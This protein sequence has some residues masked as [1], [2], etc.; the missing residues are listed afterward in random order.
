[1]S[2]DGARERVLVAGYVPWALVDDR[3]LVIWFGSADHG[4]ILAIDLAAPPAPEVTVETIATGLPTETEAGPLVGT[5]RYG[6]EELTAGNPI[7]PHVVLDLSDAPTL[8]LDA[9]IL[10]LWEQADEVEQALARAALPGRDRAAAFAARS[11]GRRT[12][13]E[14]PPGEASRVEVPVDP[15]EDEDLC[16]TAESVPGTGLWRVLVGHS[17]GDGCY[18]EYRLYDPAAKRF[19]EEAWASWLSDAWVARDGSAFVTSAQLIR[20]DRGPVASGSR[21]DLPGDVV[22]GGWL[23][24]AYYLGP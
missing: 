11:A 16:G 3:A 14:A 17:C 19:H 12:R 20:F 1:V 18:A 15:C 22:G 9:T 2:A 21:D 4:S 6:D 23:G 13:L 5:I 7:A 10:E 24:S 8:R